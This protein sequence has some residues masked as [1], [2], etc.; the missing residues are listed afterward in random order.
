M[1]LHRIPPLLVVAAALLCAPLASAAHVTHADVKTIVVRS[2]AT[3]VTLTKDTPPLKTI[4]AGDVLGVTDQLKNVGAQFG[5]PAGAIVGSDRGTAVQL[6]D[7]STRFTGTAVLPGGT[8]SISGILA[9]PGSTLTVTG[10]TGDYQGVRGTLVVG[11][12][13]TPLNTYRLIFPI[14]A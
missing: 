4:N 11:N 6:A 12:G 8:V 5:R 7:G 9:S 13:D 1:A 2:V 3:K 14:A 10:G